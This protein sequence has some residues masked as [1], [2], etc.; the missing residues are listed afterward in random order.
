[1]LVAVNM[2]TGEGQKELKGKKRIRYKSSCLD[3]TRCDCCKRSRRHGV[4]VQRFSARVT[5][6]MP[7]KTSLFPGLTRRVDV[8]SRYCLTRANFKHPAIRSQQSQKSFAILVQ[9]F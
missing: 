6:L 8:Y 5:R 2:L 3:I 1:M 9:M 4:T 7:C